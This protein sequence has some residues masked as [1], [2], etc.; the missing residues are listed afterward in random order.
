MQLWKAFGPEVIM[1]NR[2][3]NRFAILA[4]ALSGAL[5]IGA[6][7]QTTEE[8]PGPSEQPS[9]PMEI[10]QGQEPGPD[11]QPYDDSNAQPTEAQPG[12]PSGEAPATT[13]QGVGRISLIHGDVSTQRGDSGD[14]S[15]AALNQPLMT[16][17][18]VS[19]ADDAR[20]ELQLDF[21]NTLRLGPNTKTNIANLTRKN[22][23]I[24]LGEGIATYTASKDS[25]AEP[26]IDTPNVSI[27]PAHQDGVFRVEVQPDGDTIVI[28]RKGEAQIATP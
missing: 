7:A 22:I 1:K 19:T 17:D 10:G 13:D 3:R 23:Q 27:H 26:E 21:A 18:K 4:L 8:G 2:L 5:S 24:Q 11:S 25:E 14:W 20:A 9:A 15:A 12:G 6:F 16:G 28:V